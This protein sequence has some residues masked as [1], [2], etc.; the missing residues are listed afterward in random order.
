MFRFHLHSTETGFIASSYDIASCLCVLLITYLG[1]KG[2][3]PLWIGWGV[4]IMGT[5]SLV[6]AMP[7][8]FAPAY[9]Y[10]KEEHNVCNSVI[11]H[12]KCF[13]SNLKAYM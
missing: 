6:F 7:H 5:G 4:F 9:E 3:K 1:G 12:G 8:F 13:P 2:H 10:G 11:I